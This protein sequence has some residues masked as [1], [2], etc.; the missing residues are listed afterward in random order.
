M[1]LV[2]DVRKNVSDACLVN[3]AQAQ[4]CSTTLPGSPDSRLLIDMDCR[5]L[6]L[7]QRASRCDFIFVSDDGDWVVPIELKRGRV[8]A[9]E[10]VEQLRAGAR[11]AERVIPRGAAVNFRPVTVHGGKIHPAERRALLRKS[12]QIRFRGKSEGIELLRCGQPLAAAL[13]ANRRRA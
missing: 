6:G 12:A 5:E 1:G 10:V 13:R 8:R 11:F 4:G 2:D 9:S 3:R 7:N